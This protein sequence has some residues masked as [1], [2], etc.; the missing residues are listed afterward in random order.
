MRLFKGSSRFRPG[1]GSSGKHGSMKEEESTIGSELSD[2]DQFDI[3]LQGKIHK[4]WYGREGVVSGGSDVSSITNHEHRS[5]KHT[6]KNSDESGWNTCCYSANGTETT[7]AS[8]HPAQAKAS[9]PSAEKSQSDCYTWNCCSPSSV[10][11]GLPSGKKSKRMNSP[12][13]LNRTSSLFDVG[14]S[15]DESDCE[16]TDESGNKK[17][18]WK[19]SFRRALPWRRNKKNRS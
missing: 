18:S 12:R 8:M 14:Y 5:R 2:S 1:R 7:S 10:A 19:P 4:N 15:D 9:I 16:E 11:D 13:S 17:R 6:Y 3:I